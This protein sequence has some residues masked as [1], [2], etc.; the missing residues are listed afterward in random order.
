[1]QIRSFHFIVAM[2]AGWLQREQG[3]VIEYLKEEN[4]RAGYVAR[5][6]RNHLETSLGRSLIVMVKP[7]QDWPGDDLAS[8]NEIIVGSAK[9]DGLGVALMRP[10]FIEVA[11]VLTYDPAEVL[12]AH[13]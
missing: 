2:V 6:S 11:N 5:P 7:T 12:F 1:M 10:A 3:T 8:D 13:E 9:R 4:R